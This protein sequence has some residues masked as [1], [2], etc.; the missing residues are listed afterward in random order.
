MSMLL[1]AL[2]VLGAMGSPALAQSLDVPV[3]PERVAAR[4]WFQSA[5]FGMFIHWG[6]YSQLGQGEWVMQNRSIRIDS[7]EW[8][9]SAFNP[10]KFSARDWVSVA[11]RRREPVAKHR[12]A[13]GRNDP[14][15]GR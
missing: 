11:K 10:V 8:L 4:A 6:V 12:S 2:I 9:A 15:R 5:K 14:A 7:Y 13:S 3:P 1:Q